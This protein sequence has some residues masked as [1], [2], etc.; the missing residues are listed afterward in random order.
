MMSGVAAIDCDPL[1]AELARTKGAFDNWASNVVSA[2]DQ[3]RDNH[4]RNI[5][6]LTSE[7][8]P[9]AVCIDS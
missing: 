6:E 7:L 9:F 4:K 2:A 1:N 5:F 8:N 3:L